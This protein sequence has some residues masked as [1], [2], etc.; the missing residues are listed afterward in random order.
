MGRTVSRRD[1]QRRKGERARMSPVELMSGNGEL[2]VVE[3]QSRARE[4]GMELR[5]VATGR[6]GERR[7]GGGAWTRWKSRGV[8]WRRQLGPAAGQWASLTD[9]DKWGGV[10]WSCEHW[11]CVRLRASNL[12][13]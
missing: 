13:I 12:S 6:C 9:G 2:E 7:A 5:L 10:L 8:D 3:V 1:M 11:S 4:L